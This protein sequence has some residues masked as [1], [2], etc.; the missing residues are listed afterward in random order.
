[1]FY[2]YVKGRDH[3]LLLEGLDMTNNIHAPNIILIGFMG[4]GKTVIGRQTA[5]L[6][7]F[8]FADTDEEIHQVTGMELTQL[9]K[10]HGEIRFRSEEKLVTQKLAKQ[11][12]LVIACGGSLPP[13]EEN[14][15]LLKNNGWFVLLTA[16][17]KIIKERLA[18]KQNRLLIHGRPT[19]EAISDMIE[20][21][22]KK[23]CPLPELSNRQRQFK[24]RRSGG[25]HRF[26]IPP[27]F[28]QTRPLN[29]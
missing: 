18:R 22:K 7:N 1:M 20:Q 27:G 26:G 21:W 3:R 12:R 6:L 16:A 17:P 8:D 25:R 15:H 11:E 10:K 19:P 5:R 4:S 14:L 28:P 24:H 9:F 13:I 2:E 23:L 29:I